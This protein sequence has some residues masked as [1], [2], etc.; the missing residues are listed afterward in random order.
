MGFFNRA[1]PDELVANEWSQFDNLPHRQS[2]D[3]DNDM[4]LTSQDQDTTSSS[5]SS[6]S[7]SSNPL[8][9]LGTRRA[10][11]NDVESTPK[12][13]RT[14][15]STSGCT[16]GSSSSPFVRDCLD[17]LIDLTPNKSTNQ[18][19]LCYDN[20][21]FQPSL[22]NPS[23]YQHQGMKFR[24]LPQGASDLIN[25]FDDYDDEDALHMVTMVMG[26]NL[27]ENR[28]Q[29]MKVESQLAA[30]QRE[31][32]KQNEKNDILMNHNAELEKKIRNL[33][34]QKKELEQMLLRS[35]RSNQDCTRLNL[36]LQQMEKK[37][38]DEKSA[39]ESAW[40]MEKS[41]WETEKLGFMTEKSAW[42][43]EKLGFEA[44]IVQLTNEKSDTQA[45]NREL[46][47][48]V[49]KFQ[50]KNAILAKTIQDLSSNSE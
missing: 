50:K 45:Q 36:L 10:F 46:T 41:A 5:S 19:S 49:G 14:S 13:L 18:P 24:P 40:E 44:A 34:E 25:K 27:S 39:L 2:D 23:S 26:K 22:Q 30:L 29:L 1:S 32:S 15:D 47:M 7:S 20:S 9:I 38:A 37:A 4:M 43:T 33:Y 3:Y 16:S 8:S 28:K 31:H 11:E 21:M 17:L 42:E 12:R 35:E 48:T 6:S